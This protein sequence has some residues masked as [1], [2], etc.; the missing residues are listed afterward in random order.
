MIGKVVIV[1]GALLLVWGVSAC[2]TIEVDVANSGQGDDAPVA[3]LE[4][5]IAGTV[6]VTP[7][8]TA[9][10]TL[11]VESPA[12]PS[13]SAEAPIAS[14]TPGPVVQDAQA[15]W[16]RFYD[17]EHGIALWYPP[18]ATAVIG[19][20][21]RPVFSSVEFPDGIVEEQVFVV[22][23]MQEEGGPFGP[24]GPQLIL[25]VK[26]VANPDET[27]AAI[28]A[29]RYSQRCP[30]PISD[31]LQPMTVSVGLSGFR[32]SCEGIDGIIFNEFW[33]PDP[34]DP[35]LLLGATWADMSSPLA[36]EVLATIT[37]TG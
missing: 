14:A 30:G 22:R 16:Q 31:S 24:S 3:G 17:E 20:P 25:E 36:D 11:P 28:M 10:E 18:G 2:G 1:L 5:T 19:E 4:A 27:N 35:Q 21:S 32:T 15:D 34:D 6:A 23:V 9:T 7:T 37:F 29:E 33:A 13:P 26:L 12:T 8:T